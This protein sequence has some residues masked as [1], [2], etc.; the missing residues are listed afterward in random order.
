M[1][2]I[3]I[4]EV[5]GRQ[6]IMTP[7]EAFDAGWD[8]P[9]QMGEFGVISARTC[10]NCGINKTVWFALT[11]EKKSIDELTPK[12]V[13]VLDRIQKEPASIMPDENDLES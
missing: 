1:K 6:E 5:C 10:P 9:P 12:Q 3:H 4:C 11:V 13:E 8:Y 2:L 7:E